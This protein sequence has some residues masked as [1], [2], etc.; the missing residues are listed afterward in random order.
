MI[1]AAT[2]VAAGVFLLGRTFPLMSPDALSVITFTGTT[3]ALFAASIGLTAFDLKA[4]LAYSTVSQLGF[5]VAA[6][7][8]GGVAAGMF[9]MVTHAFF[10]ACLFLSAGSVI[11]GC[12]H[13]QDMRKMGGLRRRMPV[14]FACMLACTIAI[15][16]IPLFSGF[17]S[18][19]Q[20]IARAFEKVLVWFDGWSLYAAVALPLAATLTA[21]YMFRLIFMTFTG[22]YRGGEAQH[23]E[24][25]PAHAH[26]E[27][28]A[29]SDHGSSAGDAH[30]PAAHPHGDHGHGGHRHEPH[31]SPMTMLVALCVLAFLGV[32]GGHFW[33]ASTD[34]FASS[35]RPWFS[36]LMQP[37]EHGP[38]LAGLYGDGIAE[39]LEPG[40]ADHETEH[41]AHQLAVGVSLGVALIGIAGAWFLYNRRKDLPAKIT[42]GLGM[43]YT[44]VRDKYYIDEFVSATVVRATLVLA[45][46][47]TW[48]DEHVVDGLVLLVGKLNK[49]WG[50]VAAWFDQT[51][52][53]GAV[54]G[55]GLLSQFFGA[56]LRLIQTGRIQQYAAFAV[57]GGLL[58]SAWLILS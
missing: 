11:H 34:P 9:H 17:Y 21:F 42:A 22:D 55:V 8:L 24:V 7:G 53:D 16:G 58:V 23:A 56:T 20:I 4:V 51:F 39:W 14:T 40:P 54:N 48:F 26:G 2:M 10:K 15:A 33:L 13:E 41:T 12:H 25:L 35:E 1:H 30:A 37:A 29:P 50:F 46:V 44:I 43:A 32:F 19:D 47:Q 45:R 18:K 38:A 52:V 57:G 49:A 31:E 3:T 28:G 5:M 36:R 27:H 6:V